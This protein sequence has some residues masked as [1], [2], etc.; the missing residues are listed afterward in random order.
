MRI[1]LIISV[2]CVLVFASVGC[3]KGC[4][5]DTGELS[6]SVSLPSVPEGNPLARELNVRSSGFVSLSGRVK[7][8]GEPGFLPSQPESTEDRID[9]TFLFSGLLPG[10]TF[11]W[12]VF[13]SGD[14]KNSLQSGE[15][16]T[17]VLPAWTPVPNLLINEGDQA[18]TWFAVTINGVGDDGDRNQLVIV[19]DRLAR[20]RLFH[21]TELYDGI[22]G[23]FLEGLVI[24]DNGDL[25]WNNRT[26]VVA[27]NQ[28]GEEYLLF[29]VKLTG[30][31]LE[32]SHH[33]SWVFQDEEPTGLV[34]FN[35]F[36]PGVECDL[37]TPTE[38]AVGD[39]VA[40]L[41][42][43]GFEVWRWTVF[44]EPETIDPESLSPCDCD[45]GFWGPDTYDFS[46]ANNVHPV[47]DDEA[48]I[49]SIRNLS[50]VVKVD[51]VTGEIIWQLGEGLDF[52]WIGSEPENERW[53]SFQHDAQW[54]GDDRLL[55]FDNH[56]GHL[57]SCE[58]SPW[59]RAVEYEVDQ[60]AMT[61]KL[62]WEHRVPYAHANGNNERLAN[63]NT[64][65][66]GGGNRRLVEVTPDGQEVWAVQF[67]QQLPNL[68]TGRAFPALWE[69]E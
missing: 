47:D 2:V 60:S 40:L 38:N 52:K 14:P 59:S 24:L 67:S 63:G 19:Y 57:A 22:M 34:L 20:P 61:V 48:F 39:G 56:R 68:S 28:I 8:K 25:A 12:E 1:T 51:A 31:H 30:P 33:Q 37:E 69:I 29:D 11:Y 18:D 35:L 23:Q 27:M 64:L 6:I 49:V 55:I 5:G 66:A 17:P 45:G 62:V 21:E 10:E 53:F 58:P 43:E 32:S 41:D 16:T 7:L 13:E 4:D 54:L 26:D 50:R 65:I 44:D 36:G 46:H 15:F 3:G 9:H 42:T